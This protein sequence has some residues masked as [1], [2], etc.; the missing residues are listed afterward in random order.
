MFWRSSAKR[1]E[2]ASSSGF[3]VCLHCTVSILARCCNGP[4]IHTSRFLFQKKI[5]FS[6]MP[7]KTKKKEKIRN[8]LFPSSSSS[9]FIFYFSFKKKINKR[10]KI[11]MAD[12]T[13][14]LTVDIMTD[15][16]SRISDSILT[17]LT[18]L[19]CP[20]HEV[21]YIKTHISF[22]YLFEKDIM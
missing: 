1:R 18:V 15:H 2:P 20:I 10:I 5:C 7:L 17:A 9:K 13:P 11:Q 19:S 14:C 21:C 3:V 16:T 6:L 12:E 22:V 8:S 4:Y